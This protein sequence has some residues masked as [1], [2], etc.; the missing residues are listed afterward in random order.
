MENHA[1]YGESIY[2]QAGDTL[3]VNLFLASTLNWRERGLTLAQTTR[4]PDAD[5]TGLVFQTSK[6]QTLKLAIR[7]PGWCAAMTITVNGKRK[8]VSRRPGSYY[9]L[10]RTFSS[11]DVVEVRLPM[12]LKLAPLRSAPGNAS[13]EWA[14]LTYGPIALAGRLGTA[15]LTPGSQLIVNERESGNMLSETVPIPR[16]NR[17]LTELVTST[18]RNDPDSLRFT[19]RGFDGGASVELIPWFRL[20][21]ER[22][23]LYWQ[24]QNPA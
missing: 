1:R 15:G 11:G 6:P 5:T 13:M 22:Y 21:H 12:S 17:P 16:W 9:S 20:A 19:T 4:F 8:I 2:A 7:H 23:N 3:Y 14:A 10:T 24:G 18:T